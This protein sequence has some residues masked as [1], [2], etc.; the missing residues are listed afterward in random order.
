MAPAVR[1]RRRRS[2]GSRLP[3][4][5]VLV[6]RRTKWANPYRIL[7]GRDRALRRF[8]E[9]LIAGRLP[10][11]VDDVRRELRGRNLACDCSLDVDCHA[12]ILLEVANGLDEAV[13]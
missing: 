7:L 9:D 6:T 13:A 5:T 3:A 1:F 8:A 12:D 10:Y 11:T 2:A 4:E